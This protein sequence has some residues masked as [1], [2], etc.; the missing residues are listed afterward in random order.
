M[1]LLKGVE[2]LTLS[3]KWGKQGAQKRG[4]VFKMSVCL[5]VW[6]SVCLSVCLYVIALR[7]N[8]NEIELEN[9]RR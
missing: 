7:S 4:E 1:A 9:S 5:S 6:V 8:E 3:C 2:G